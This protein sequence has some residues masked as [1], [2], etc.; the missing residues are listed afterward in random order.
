ML[1]VLLGALF[2]ASTGL[3]KST[4]ENQKKKLYKAETT[5]K[6]EQE[7]PGTL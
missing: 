1:C 2:H 6:K 3:R 4:I 5:N 7:G